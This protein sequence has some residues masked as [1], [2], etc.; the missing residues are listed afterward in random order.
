MKFEELWV[1]RG[2]KPVLWTIPYWLTWDEREFEATIFCDMLLLPHQLEAV[3][4]LLRDCARPYNGMWRILKEDLEKIGYRVDP[5]D[6][7]PL[8]FSWE[9]QKNYQKEE[10]SEIAERLG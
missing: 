7:A 5:P 8:Y 10:Y 1:I 3:E 9:R 6:N 4:N 2:N